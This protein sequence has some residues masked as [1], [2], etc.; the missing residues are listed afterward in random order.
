MV[1]IHHEALEKI[2]NYQ[3]RVREW[4]EKCFG[5]EI[6]DDTTERNHRFLEEALELVQACGITKSECLQ[7]ID[8][9]Y[10]RPAG[11]KEQEVGGVMST[12]ATLCAAHRMN[13]EECAERELIKVY[14][15]IDKIREKR[16]NKPKHSPLPQ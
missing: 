16:A 15:K 10:S 7:L 3:A 1:Q 12:L 8:Y 14:E 2:M 6:A 4:A 11:D 5:K 13:L 9:V